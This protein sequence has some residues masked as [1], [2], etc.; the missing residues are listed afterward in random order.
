MPKAVPV[1]LAYTIWA[2]MGVFLTASISV[3]LRKQIKDLLAIVGMCLIVTGVV[4]MCVFSKA[5][6]YYRL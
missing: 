1:G 5:V 4:V 6:S 3:V 2:A